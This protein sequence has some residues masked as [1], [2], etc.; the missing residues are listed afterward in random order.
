MASSIR[1]T[2][3]NNGDVVYHKS[4]YNQVFKN[5][6]E[7][8]TLEQ[9]LYAIGTDIKL[10]TSKIND[11]TS[12]TSNPHTV[13]K[14]QVG[15]G[16]VD[17]TADSNKNVRSASRVRDSANEKDINITYA[18]TAQ[19]S[20]N[21]LASWN[22]YEI[23]AITPENIIKNKNILTVA[24]ANGYYGLKLPNGS[25]SSW[26]RTTQN[27]I[28]PYQSGGNGSIGTSSW[29]FSTVYANTYY[30]G[31]KT[32]AS[33]YAAAT[34]S[35]SGYAA[36]SHTHS[37]LPLS[38]GTLTG[39]LSI[40]PYLFLYENKMET[41]PNGYPS[42]TEM[43]GAWILSDTGHIYLK[44]CSQY[45]RNSSFSRD[46]AVW[47]FG[48]R[49]SAATYSLV[50]RKVDQDTAGAVSAASYDRVS[51]RKAKKNIK[52]MSCKLA[53]SILDVEVVT[54]DY[55]KKNGGEKN[56]RGVIAEDVN[57]IMPD[58]CNI[59]TENGIA[60]VDYSKFVPYLIKKVQMMDKEINEL[61]CKLS[62]VKK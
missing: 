46:G 50:V 49:P 20:T 38:G 45:S 52:P 30:E 15:L 23:G 5:D 62:K 11:H 47:V 9:A 61:K 24:S 36:A 42:S 1:K 4:L 28:I 33:K 21:Y 18:K 12:N 51:S 56:C 35:H 58:V 27:G 31:G 60:G 2:H 17:N 57:E 25:T 39:Q 37:Y 48:G 7:T 13:T 53:N 32:L 3:A 44:A 14:S 26:V 29:P 10:N 16:N 19:T 34:H 40:S 8:E 43:V 59:D 22:G 54:F 41:R 6:T 55:R